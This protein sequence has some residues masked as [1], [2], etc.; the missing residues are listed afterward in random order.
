MKTLPE[1]FDKSGW[2]HEQKWRQ[3]MV[4]IY[5]RWKE[6]SRIPHYEVI[7][8]SENAEHEIGGVKIP[9]SESYPTEKQWGTKGFTC[10]DWNAA[11]DK[12]I[13]LCAKEE[14]KATK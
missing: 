9:A 13:E 8:I 7:R 4:A 3:G 6:T 12:A 11:L 10:M 2:H 14:Q 1:T 5:S